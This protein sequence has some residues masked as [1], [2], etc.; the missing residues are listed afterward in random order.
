M[1]DRASVNSVMMRT[2]SI[3]YNQITDIGCSHTIDHV[4]EKMKTPVLD[5]FFKAL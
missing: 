3:V 2:V 4:G 5:E 1:Y